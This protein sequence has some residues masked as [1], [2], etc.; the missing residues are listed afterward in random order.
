MNAQPL[1]GLRIVNTRASRQASS[2]TRL[3]EAEGAEVLHYPTVEIKPCAD[4]GKLDAALKELA[5][6][7]FDWLVITSAN[8]VYTLADRLRTLGIQ[9]ARI[10]QH[11]TMVAAVGSATASAVR[12]ELNLSVDLLPDAYVAESLAAS[13][14]VGRGSRV[15]LPQSALARPLLVNTLRRVGAEVAAVTAYRTVVGH[16]GDDLPRHFRQGNVDAVV[17]TS[18]STVHNFVERLKAEIPEESQKERGEGKIPAGREKVSNC[19]L[20]SSYF[21]QLNLAV[22]CIGPKTAEAARGHEL[23]VQVVADDRTVEGLVHSLKAYF[24]GHPR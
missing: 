9:H 14:R 6:G 11:S 12:E 13:L 22:A 10:A 19:S 20:L 16:G 17:F 3:L 21:S 2:L 18:A 24:A 15:L 23:P 8:T 7:R 1:T 5:A 4:S